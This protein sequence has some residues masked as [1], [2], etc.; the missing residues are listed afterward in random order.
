MFTTPPIHR[1]PCGGPEAGRLSLAQIPKLSPYEATTA[2]DSSWSPA[3]DIYEDASHFI[4]DAQLPGIDPEGVDVAVEE[5]NVT[6]SGRKQWTTDSTGAA[7]AVTEK[8]S[9]P[10]LRGIA[11]PAP[12][13]A[14]EVR[15][16]FSNGVLTILLPKNEQTPLRPVKIHFVR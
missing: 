13:K 7:A 10:F 16:C 1:S 3:V 12:V 9:G 6:I 11:L 5:R 4:V 2:M 8:G 15:C 14:G